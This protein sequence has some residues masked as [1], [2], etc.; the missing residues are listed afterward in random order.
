[1]ARNAVS[2]IASE[3]LHLVDDVTGKAW[4][5][6]A[7]SAV[8][9]ATLCY[10]AVSGSTGWVTLF[11]AVVQALT[12]IL[13]FVVQHTQDRY[14]QITQRKLDALLRAL[15]DAEPGVVYLEA[16]SDEQVDALSERHARSGRR[17][18]GQSGDA[19]R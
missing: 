7:L 14:Q 6:A 15:P 5:A 3:L 10:G 17:E 9:L 8:T 18:R 4:I 2:R 11:A 12:L 13:V 19:T 1:M 16:A